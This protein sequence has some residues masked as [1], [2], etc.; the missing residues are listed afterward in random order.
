MINKLGK[1]RYITQVDLSKGFWQIPVEELDRHFLAF[2][3][4]RGLMQ[5]CKMPFGYVNSSAV[6]CRLV[7]KL[8]HD[9]DDIDGYI[10]NL[11]IATEEW[12]PH[13]VALRKL[14]ER[15]RQHK[16]TVR[17]SKC[18][19]GHA[20]VDLLGHTVGE[21]Q[22]KSQSDKV[23]KI[24]NVESPST[25]ELRSFLGMVSYYQKFIPNFSTIAKPLTDKTKGR[26]NKLVWDETACETAFSKLKDVIS[27]YPVLR[28]PDFDKPFIL[29]TDASSDG[30]CAV[31][32]QEHDGMKMPVMY[33]SRKLKPAETRYSTIELECL[34]LVWAT[35]RLNAYFC[36]KEFILETDQQPLLFIDRSKIDNDRIMRWTLSMQVYKAGFPLTRFWAARLG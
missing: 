15:L 7:R 32:L 8:L 36:G 31:L 29:A 6:F 13:I 24:F 2:K 10:D 19:L 25:K 12:E 1:A 23:T 21:G 18:E 33:I 20:V 11:V 5:F 9:I 16:M 35:K 4:D 34:A 27:T 26:T 3:T 17:P 14:C 30:I 22:V 28:L